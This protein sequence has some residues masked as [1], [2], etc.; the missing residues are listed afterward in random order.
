[1]EE[2]LIEDYIRE[3]NLV[4]FPTDNR[5]YYHKLVSLIISQRIRFNVGRKIRS[6]IYTVLGTDSLD[7]IMS[8][9]ESQR[10]ECGLGDS[11][12]ETIKALSERV[13]VEGG[14]QDSSISEIR[15]IGSWTINCAK[16][17]SGDYSCG[18]LATDLSVNNLVRKIVNKPLTDREIGK[19][20]KGTRERGGRAF[21]ALWNSVR[22]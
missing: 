3:N 4:P 14:L 10:K 7:N 1:M 13:A 2:N 9:T 21:S 19:L 17:M 8:L 11:K 6:R 5:S 20:F 18:F 15:G 22:N 12:W 16:L